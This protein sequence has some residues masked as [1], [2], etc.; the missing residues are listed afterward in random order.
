VQELKT[1]VA[2]QKKQIEVLTAG[3]QEVSAQTEIG[4]PAPKVVLNQ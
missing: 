1:T 4:R 2:E 3:L